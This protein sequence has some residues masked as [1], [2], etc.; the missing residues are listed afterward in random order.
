MHRR[1]VLVLLFTAATYTS[2]ASLS[3]RNH[4]FEEPFTEGT[5]TGP[6]TD[7]F[8]VANGDQ[9]AGVV[10][11]E[12]IGLVSPDEF[13]MAWIRA[14]W[15]YQPN[16]GINQVLDAVYGPG[17]Y[18]L[19]FSA[20]GFPGAT[21]NPKTLDAHLFAGELGNNIASL[22]ATL[23]D[24]NEYSLSVTLVD[25]DAA[26]GQAI[27]IHFSNHTPNGSPNSRILI[28]NVVLLA[29]EASAVAWNPFPASGSGMGQTA[30][31]LSWTPGAHAATHVI[32]L[33]DSLP[34]LENGQADYVVETTEPNLSLGIAEAPY[35]DGLISG[36]TYYWRVD[37]VNE[38]NP[39]SPWRG[40][41]WSFT[42]EPKT[43]H[44]PYPTNNAL[45]VESSP[46]LSW[47]AGVG[48]IEHA[49]LF[50]TDADAIRGAAPGSGILTTDPNYTPA[51]LERGTTYYWRVDESDG[52][53]LHPGDLWSF[54]TQPEI[55]VE[56][57]RLKGWWMLNEGEGV[58]AV[59]SSGHDLHGDLLGGPTWSFG[60]LGGALEFDG[61]DDSVDTGYAEDLSTWT[62]SAWVKG[63]AA[64]MIGDQTGPVSRLANYQITWNHTFEEAVGAIIMSTGGTVYRTQ[65]AQLEADT[66]YH[67]T[68]TFDGQT[69]RAYTNG[70]LSGGV[71]AVAGTSAATLKFG[72]QTNAPNYWAGR[73]SDVRV[74]E[75]ALDQDAIKQIMRGDPLIAWDPNP[76]N[77]STVD[78]LKNALSWSSGDS[79]VSHDLYLGTERTVVAEADIT[80]GDV[81]Q[82]RLEL[83]RFE[84]NG[85]E[86]GRRYFWRVDEVADDGSLA[87]GLIWS[88]T[89][90]SNYLNIDDFEG[91]SG[92]EGE[93]VYLTWEDGFG[94]FAELGGS[95]SGH[96][97]APFVEIGK[98]H[99]GAKS[100]PLE[101]DNDGWFSD[102][103]GQP[104]NGKTY[105]KIRR[106][107]DPPEN[108][109]HKAG[110]EFD[111]LGL[112]FY[113]DPDNSQEPIFLQITDS[114]DQSVT[115]NYTDDPNAIVTDTWSPWVIEL[116][117][118]NIDLTRIESLEIG[119]GDLTNER[120]GLNGVILIDDI[121]LYAIVEEGND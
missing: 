82:G 104:L 61:N 67:L 57:D 54:T 77:G 4:S 36:T 56:D 30:P 98:K 33:D 72:R 64:P 55:P 108:W 109:V 66:W 117:S 78:I 43:A 91:Y 18:T 26:V 7:W 89:V 34:N 113:G 21:F 13:Q 95:T 25:T 48:A 2:A 86:A 23:T 116:A 100:L 58:V 31:V 27:G 118:L 107:F 44:S 84:L 42:I 121:R 96:M 69:L 114:A 74:Y 102:F 94:G 112:W 62:V 49:V 59:D 70:E 71:P 51:D 50:G 24:V 39:D 88:F 8:E 65:F 79:A 105:S 40:V 45:Y 93:E 92:R 111:T 81:Y 41:I 90:A 87:G 3:I 103:N 14:H 9:F 20:G 110:L 32:S 35:P 101:Y 5:D 75:G 83:A 12:S 38:A 119:V 80:N 28:D 99:G 115:L 29:P 16:Q 11:D 19:T 1:T 53:E 47:E 15:S 37:E 120:A 68:G 52:A 17:T 22:K 46:T 76:A 85:L 106:V 60:L 97:N 6:I 73:L 10:F 63:D